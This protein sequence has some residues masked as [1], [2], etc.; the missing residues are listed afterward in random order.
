MGSFL[1][2]VSP[3]ASASSA[4]IMSNKSSIG[5]SALSIST[6]KYSSIVTVANSFLED[7]TANGGST[8]SCLSEAVSLKVGIG[9]VGVEGDAEHSSCG[10]Q[11]DSETTDKVVTELS[12]SVHT[13]VL[14]G[15]D[16]PLFLTDLSE[17]VWTAWTST[18]ADQPVEIERALRPIEDLFDMMRAE[19]AEAV[20]DTAT[21]KLL[22]I[23][24]LYRYYE[25][26]KANMPDYADG[27]AAADT[28][29]GECELDMFTNACALGADPSDSTTSWTT[30]VWGCTDA[31]KASCDAQ[32]ACRWVT[33]EEQQE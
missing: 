6:G 10:S 25:D 13:E 16:Q 26:A 4:R 3:T 1:V 5:L 24:A 22:M 27:T 8:S 17:D 23:H 29:G 31:D 33:A 11:T 32:A 28:D 19:D 20:G 12:S 15:T 14:G 18:I 9:S 30:D 7:I 2:A 21:K